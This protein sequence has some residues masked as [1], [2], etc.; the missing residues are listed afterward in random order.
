[1]DLRKQ[2]LFLKA[3]IKKLEKKLPAV[4]KRII[5]LERQLA[6]LRRQKDEAYE[7]L[8]NHAD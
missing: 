8:I 4:E 1:V 6:H 5:S 3:S 7:H 2:H